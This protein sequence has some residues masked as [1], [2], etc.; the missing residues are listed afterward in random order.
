[1]LLE[2]FRDRVLISFLI[3]T[4]F[5]PLFYFYTPWKHQKTGG[6][7]MFS[8]GIEVE[9]WLKIGLVNLSELAK[10]Y[11]PWNHQETK[12]FPVISGGAEVHRF[13]KFRDRPLYVLDIWYFFQKFDWYLTL[14]FMN[15]ASSCF[16]LSR[17][18][19]SYCIFKTVRFSDDSWG[20]RNY[21]ALESRPKTLWRYNQLHT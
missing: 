12:D 5:Q 6:F 20:N 14:F 13:A 1:M 10:F 16:V 17:I 4:H 11:L 18:W 21:F 15:S 19:I 2:N 7:L 3:L 9:H 8:G